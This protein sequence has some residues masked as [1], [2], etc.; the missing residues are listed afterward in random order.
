MEVAQLL[1]G[2][3]AA[4]GLRDQAGLTPGDV[5]R[6]RNHW[7]L[8]TLLEGAGP[9]EAR[10]KPTPGRGGSVHGILQ[11]RTLEWIAMASSGGS[12]RPRDQT[13]ISYVSCIIGNFFMVSTTWEVQI[14]GSVQSL[15]RV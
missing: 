11:V 2:L 5:A 7:D 14:I 10:H 3:G 13:C 12:S 6:Q 4:Q 9:P 8:L 1:L 15:S